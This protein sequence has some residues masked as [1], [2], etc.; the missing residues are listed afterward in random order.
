M[1]SR[2]SPGFVGQLNPALTAAVSSHAPTRTHRRG[3]NRVSSR[4]FEANIGHGG[5]KERGTGDLEGK[6]RNLDSSEMVE[7]VVV[8]AAAV[9]L[10]TVTPCQH[11]MDVPGRYQ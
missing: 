2:L 11:V 6:T 8:P 7:V 4:S 3:N 5:T 1:G 10:P 9:E